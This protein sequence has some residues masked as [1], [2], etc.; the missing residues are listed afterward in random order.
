MSDNLITDIDT[1]VKKAKDLASRR[2]ALFQDKSSVQAEL[3]A[4]RRNLKKLM[5]EAEALGFDPNNLKEELQ[6]KIE[7][8]RTKLQVYE[9]DLQTA[10]AMIKPMLEEIRKS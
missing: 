10:E 6:R 1:L 5:D 3:D 2:E 8:E 9:S 7:V 4:R